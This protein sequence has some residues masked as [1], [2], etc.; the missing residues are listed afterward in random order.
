MDEDPPLSGPTRSLLDYNPSWCISAVLPGSW[1]SYPFG[2]SSPIGR[3]LVVKPE[4]SSRWWELFS[5]P[6]TVRQLPGRKTDMDLSL[7]PPL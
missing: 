7:S 2:V 1:W 4:A 3:I 6:P 5:V